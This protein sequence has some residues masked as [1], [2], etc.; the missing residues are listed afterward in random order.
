MSA[1]STVGTLEMYVRI[2]E[3]GDTPSN[4]EMV[5]LLNDLSDYLAA[6]Y[7]KDTGTKVGPALGW[8]TLIQQP[9]VACSSGCIQPRFGGQRRLL[10][11]LRCNECG[12]SFCFLR[13]SK[14]HDENCTGR[15]VNIA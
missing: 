5:S 11:R 3:A 6:K 4:A 13:C 15:C 1:E 10:P 9:F 7:H 8:D 14:R 2:Y 12:E